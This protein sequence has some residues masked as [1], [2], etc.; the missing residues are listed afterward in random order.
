MWLLES[1]RLTLRRV[2]FFPFSPF[3]IV[4]LPSPLTAAV[5]PSLFYQR[6]IFNHFFGGGA[7]ISPLLSR[8][9]LSLRWF[10]AIR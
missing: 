10:E 4:T 5:T 1:A 7:E 2:F 8:G 3:L 6:S 9:S